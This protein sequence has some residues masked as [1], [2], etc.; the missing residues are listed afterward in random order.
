[1]RQITIK[2]MLFG[3]KNTQKT[4]V[5]YAFQLFFEPKTVVFDR[6]SRQRSTKI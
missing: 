3:V 2:M 6:F 5:F 4:H 1:M